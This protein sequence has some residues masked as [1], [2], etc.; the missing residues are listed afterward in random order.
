MGRLDTTGT[1]IGADKV[2][3]TTVYNAEGE[4]LGSIHD[5]MIDKQTGRVAYAVM[6]FGG[7][8]GMGS[9]YHPLPWSTLTYDTNMG[10]YVV[11]LT[12]E[13]LEGGPTFSE[14]EDPH[15]GDRDYEK[16]VHDYYGSGPYWM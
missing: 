7:F 1:L 16:R 9:D 8:L 3:G 2:A 6:S 11:H 10:G 12:R 5:L 15:W 14:D 4:N 13:Q